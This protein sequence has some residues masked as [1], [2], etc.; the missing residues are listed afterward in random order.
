MPGYFVTGT[1][2]EVGKTTVSCALLA[3]ASARGLKAHCYKPVESGCS[4]AS[5]GTLQP[6]DA[7]A[8]WEASGRGQLRESIC[9]YRFREPIAPGVAAENEGVVIDFGII[10]RDLHE[11]QTDSPD[12]MLVEGAGGLLVPMGQ[13]RMIR[14]LA[15]TLGLRLV[16]V[17]R[18]TLGT[19]NHTLLTVE[20]A[21]GRGI[22]I[23]GIIF[24]ASSGTPDLAAVASNRAEIEQA[25]GVEILG[26]LPY[27]PAAAATD[28]G[29]AA[30]QCLDLG[31]LL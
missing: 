3:A 19:I 11:L 14:D 13:G 21:R 20:A 10:Q 17:A 22:D 1:D 18:P 31:R 27:L 25:S 2:T 29:R 9:R 24:S 30:E 4:E 28:L 16:I 15:E 23:A 7:L 6:Q 8:L 12:L 26:C 5:D